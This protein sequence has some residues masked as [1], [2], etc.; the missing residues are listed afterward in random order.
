MGVMI[1]YFLNCTSIPNR[2]HLSCIND[3]FPDGIGQ[4]YTTGAIMW[5]LPFGFQLVPCGMMLI[6]LLTVKESPRWLV[7]AGRKDEAL[8][9]LAYYRR[10]STT[11]ERV[12][13]E[14]AE[15]EAALLEEQKARE[16]LDWKEA[17]FG[18]GNFIRFVIAFVIFC[19]QQWS[20]Q[21]SVG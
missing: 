19:F 7:S 21:N 6:G 14:M 16:G 8:V 9:N 5:Q 2:E 18:K 15:I 12:M 17:F 13:E 4:S 10:E 20:G 1:S 11:S 3:V